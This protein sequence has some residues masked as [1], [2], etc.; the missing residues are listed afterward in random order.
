M[1]IVRVVSPVYGENT[2]VLTTDSAALVIDPGVKVC[3]R[4][5][6]VL[7]Q[8]DKPL[9]AVLL[10]HGHADHLWDAAQVAALGSDIPI[11]L[12]G[13]DLFWLDAPGPGVQ[14]GVGDTFSAIGG[15]WQHFD[16]VLPPSALFD[17][18]GAT[19][20]EGLQLR[21]LPAPGHSPG[22]TMFFAAGEVNDH[23][24]DLGFEPGRHQ[25]FCFSGDVIFKGS[26]GRSDLPH[27]DSQ[28]MAETLNMLKLSVDPDTLMLP[29]HGPTTSWSAEL[30]TNPFLS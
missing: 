18:G 11:Y 17:E 26:V 1:D 4:V 29:G 27:S 25:Q 6:E 23:G 7:T 28:V 9:A 22:S 30:A 10:T 12:A 8:L 19:L 13:P 16:A 5:Q 21:A 20:I 15:P 24:L 3:S 2:Y 14:L